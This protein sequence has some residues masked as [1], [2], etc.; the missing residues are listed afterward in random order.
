MELIET[1]VS[2]IEDFEVTEIIYVSFFLFGGESQPRVKTRDAV[3]HLA[4]V[5][6]LDARWS[7]NV[8]GARVQAEP[9][10]S[11]IFFEHRHFRI[12]ETFNQFFLNIFNELNVFNEITAVLLFARKAWAC[13]TTGVWVIASRKA[14][15]SSSSSGVTTSGTSTLSW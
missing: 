2:Q 5:D 7:F 6:V 14:L 8:A 11:Q 4:D 1:N 15:F 10:R 12:G 13:C 9:N 3:L